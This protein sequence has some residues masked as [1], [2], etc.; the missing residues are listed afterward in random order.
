MWIEL[1]LGSP[2]HSRSF[3]CFSMCP[4]DDDDDDDDDDGGG[5]T[6]NGGGC[7]SSSS[8]HNKTCILNLSV[9]V[10]N[11]GHYFYEDPLSIGLAV[12]IK[13]VTTCFAVKCLSTN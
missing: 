10:L 8:S 7:S 9:N 13:P 11:K 3:L 2:L 4:L 6:G 5:S 12:E 1:V